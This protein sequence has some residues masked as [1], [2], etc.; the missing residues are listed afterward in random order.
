M[1]RASTAGRH[2]KRARRSIGGLVRP[3]FPSGRLHRSIG[4]AGGSRDPGE[5]RACIRSEMQAREPG[6]ATYDV[7]ARRGAAAGHKC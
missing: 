7:R 3:P 6:T 5:I 1:S 2:D 4:P